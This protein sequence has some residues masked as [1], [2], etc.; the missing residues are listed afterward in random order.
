MMERYFMK[1]TGAEFNRM[2]IPCEV[3]VWV[4]YKAT[5]GM[6]ILSWKQRVR[7]K[8]SKDKV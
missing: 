6:S 4:L 3:Q 5:N 2:K 7:M 8:L 1:Q